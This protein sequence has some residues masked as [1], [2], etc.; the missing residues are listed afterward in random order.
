MSLIAAHPSLLLE[1]SHENEELIDNRAELERLR[2]NP[3][4][5]INGE[6]LRLSEALN[7]KVLV[8]SQ[9]IKPLTLIRGQLRESFNWIEGREVLYMDG[10]Q[11]VRLCQSSIN[12]FNDPS[13][14]VKVLLASK[15]A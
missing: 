11:D 8:F 3:E 10:K 9:Y 6:L 4:A 15:K 12:V 2:L 7:E 1:Q 5:E 13:S 14:E